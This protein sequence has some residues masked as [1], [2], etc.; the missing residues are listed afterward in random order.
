MNQRVSCGCKIPITSKCF[1]LP[2]FHTCKENTVELKING[3]ENLV[4]K[5]IEGNLIHGGIC[6]KGELFVSR[7]WK[8]KTRLLLV[9]ELEP[10]RECA[11]FLGNA[12]STTKFYRSGL[13]SVFIVV[14]V[15]FVVVAKQRAFVVVSLKLTL[16]LASSSFFSFLLSACRARHNFSS[17]S[18]LPF[19]VIISLSLCV[20]YKTNNMFQLVRDN[21]K[22]AVCRKTICIFRIHLSDICQGFSKLQRGTSIIW[23]WHAFDIQ[24]TIRK[25]MGHFFAITF[26]PVNILAWRTHSQNFRKLNSRH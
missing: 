16:S 1:S 3:I 6:L 20:R 7:P 10:K 8:K 12:F 17:F 4:L 18:I 19:C 22:N 2:L 23:K 24:S 5:L 26:S 21:L 13:Y 14:A 11:S 15:F 25:V 9:S